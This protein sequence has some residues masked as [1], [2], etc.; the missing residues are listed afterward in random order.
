MPGGVEDRP[1]G[2]Q[3]ADGGRA[4]RGERDQRGQCAEGIRAGCDPG[5]AAGEVRGR[6]RAEGQRPAGRARVGGRHQQRQGRLAGQQGGPARPGQ[7]GE[8]GIAGGQPGGHRADRARVA[9]RRAAGHAE[10]VH[11]PGRVPVEEDEQQAHRGRGLGGGGQ[12]AAQRERRHGERRDRDGGQHRGPAGHPE[13]GPG[14]RGEHDRGDRQEQAAEQEQ[15]VLH[16]PGGRLRP[17]PA[18]RGGRPV[19]QHGSAY[20]GCCRMPA[21][22]RLADP[23][24]QI[25]HRL[26]GGGKLPDELADLG[27][28][29][30]HLDGIRI[31]PASAGRAAGVRR[32]GSAAIR[33]GIGHGIDPRDRGARATEP[34]YSAAGVRTAQIRHCGNMVTIF[35]A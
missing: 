28:G 4:G 35:T 14:H 2:V 13:L 30:D 20:A 11:V 5:P 6:H 22:P 8:P 10:Q 19:G 33:A 7:P 18:G 24:L 15:D 1:G 31:G 29:P 12:L 17:G 23:P 9:Q 3:G 34:G 27:I 16:Q 25:A 32:G 26:P 21:L